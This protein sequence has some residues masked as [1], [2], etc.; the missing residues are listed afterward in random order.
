MTWSVQD[1]AGKPVAVFTPP[2]PRFTVLFLHDH[3]ER[4]PG[5]N[6]ELTAALDAHNLACIAPSG[7]Q[8]WWADRRHPAFDPETTAEQ[9]LLRLTSS[10]RH[11]V[12]PS[13]LHAPIGVGMGGQAAVRLGLKYPDRFPVVA[14]WDSAFDFHDWYGRGTALDELYDRKEQARQDTAVLHVRQHHFPGHIWFGCSPESEWFRGNDR[15]HEKLSAVGV[16]HT[17]EPGPVERPL[18]TMVAFAADALA[19]QSRRLL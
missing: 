7:G 13:P 14:G 3:D 17:F 2:Q 8:S 12:T 18:A 6:A 19:K 5:E 11:P 15:L 9:H 10:P 1:F 4:L 16:P